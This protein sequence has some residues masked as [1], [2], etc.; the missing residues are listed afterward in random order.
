MEHV[1][2]LDLAVE[3]I[4][5][6]DDRLRATGLR[7]LKA[8]DVEDHKSKELMF[9]PRRSRMPRTQVVVLK[10]LDFITEPFTYT[11]TVLSILLG[12]M[13]MGATASHWLSGGYLHPAGVSAW[14]TPALIAFGCAIVG[15]SLYF[16]IVG[17]EFHVRMSEARWVERK[18]KL[19]DWHRLPNDVRRVA[20]RAK[21]ACP[22]TWL[23]IH[24]LK[25]GTVTLDPVLEIRSPDGERSF[26]AIWDGHLVIALA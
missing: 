23:F 10:T 26:L 7:P 16:L 1:R 24:E 17:R 15:W 20:R 19:D 13:A 25:Q 8:G 12:L 22:N 9:A 21:E 14:W 11:S 3:H 5:L 4:A 18:L 2:T 6:Q